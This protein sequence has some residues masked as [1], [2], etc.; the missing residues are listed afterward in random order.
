MKR[1]VTPIVVF[2]ATAC[3]GAA[4]PTTT[5]VAPTTSASPGETTTSFAESTTT[6]EPD[7]GAFPE[8]DLPLGEPCLIDAVPESGEVT[9]VV[10]DRLYGLGGDGASP[11]CL[12]EGVTAAELDWGPD[13]DRL[14]TGSRV[15][16][17]GGA[18]TL[19]EASGYSWSSPTGT[20]V[21]AW[22]TDR[23]WKID[24][25]DLAE[26]DI[27]FL[28]ETDTAIY[29]PAGEHLLVV[30]TGFDGQYGLWLASNQGQGPILLAADEL[31]SLSEPAWT[32]LGE[33]LFTADHIDGPWHVHR[34]ELTP[35][36]ALEGPV[37]VETPEAIDMLVPSR[38]D[39][40]I[41]AYRLG[42]ESGE[43]CV[44]GARVAVNG[45]DI[46]APVAAMTSTPVGWL[47]TERL[48]IMTFPDGC[49]SPA[50][51]WSF[52]AGFCPGSEYGV[53]PIIAG[54]DG[55]AAREAAPLPPPPP[56]FT[57]IIDPA[58]A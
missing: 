10:D 41:W 7:A 8:V 31:A 43:L 55:A 4:G 15:L 35:D 56:D 38:Y 14:R 42:G 30:G 1:F 54:I 29:H 20:R 28:A 32:W 50:D 13:G 5:T 26:E 17:A 3:V 25:A 2:L 46:P 58:P 52:S 27:T 51:L 48:L 9:V 24:P 12:A 11:R 44:E 57:G 37:L 19:P 36:G 22:T 18:V 21:L 34:V 53:T 33:P 47:S 45:I 6:S 40:V 49:D 39:P 23:L 16:T